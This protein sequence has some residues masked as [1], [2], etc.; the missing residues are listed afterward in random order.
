MSTEPN[1]T[2]YAKFH[3]R[4]HRNGLT[5]KIV[6]VAIATLACAACSTTEGRLGKGEVILD[7]QTRFTEEE[8]KQK[9]RVVVTLKDSPE[10]Q[11]LS[12]DMFAVKE[13]PL[14]RKPADA[15]SSIEQATGR[16]SAYN[17]T[18]GTV[19]QAAHLTSA[20][21]KTDSAEQH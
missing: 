20:S 9:A 2:L 5:T 3:F 10:G 7:D 17:I 19:M 8:M 21:P 18:A 14:S 12:E 15:L 4:K 13:I 6:A 16:V 11:T 1:P